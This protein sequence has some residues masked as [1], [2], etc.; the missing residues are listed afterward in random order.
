MVVTH[1]PRPPSRLQ[2]TNS[3]F[4][5]LRRQKKMFPVPGKLMALRRETCTGVL[6]LSIRR[7]WGKRGKMEAKKGES[8]SPPF[9]VSH[10]KSPLP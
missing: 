6:S 10:L 5:I 7:F 1:L 9:P 4:P 3:P 2:N 8:S